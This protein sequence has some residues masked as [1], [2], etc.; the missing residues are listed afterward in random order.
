MIDIDS[1][2]EDPDLRFCLED[3]GFEHNL[4]KRVTSNSYMKVFHFMQLGR[5]S[6]RLPNLYRLIL[7]KVNS[8]IETEDAEPK[9]SFS[10]HV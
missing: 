10:P 4:W 2:D 8:Y 3:Y 6:E 9:E 1:D 5:T 7:N